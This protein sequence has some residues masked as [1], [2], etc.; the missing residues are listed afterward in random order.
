ATVRLYVGASLVGTGT[1]TGGSYSI[2][3]N[4]AL[5]DGTY[6]VTATATDAAGNVSPTGPALALTIDTTPPAAPPAPGLLV[7]DDSGA[8]GDGITNVSRPH[9][10]G[11][12]EAGSTVRLFLGGTL[13]GTATATAGT[14]SISLGSSLADGTHAVM[15]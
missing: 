7:T 13:V 2:L 6:S 11:T 1:A 12:A 5:T 4:A 3:L 10:K 8:V 14:Y 9:I 15:A